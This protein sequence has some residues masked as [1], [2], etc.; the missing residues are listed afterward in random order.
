MSPELDALVITPLASHSLSARPLVVSTSQGL[1]IEVLDSGNKRYAW[2]QVDGQV[3]MQVPV[4]GRAVLLPAPV[5]FRHLSLGPQQFFAALH[6][7]LGF[8]DLP[9]PRK[10]H[11]T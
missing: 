2:F 10:K 3:Q 4:G 1:E 5:R 9:G 6:A 11:V 8:A 7:K